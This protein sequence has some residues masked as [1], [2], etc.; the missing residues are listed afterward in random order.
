MLA[1]FASDIMHIFVSMLL[2]VN[3]FTEFKS[4]VWTLWA[5][6]AQAAFVPNIFHF[7]TSMDTAM[8][9]FLPF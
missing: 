5:A 4:I 6:I 9:C 7:T 1:A 3:S 2:A 8:S